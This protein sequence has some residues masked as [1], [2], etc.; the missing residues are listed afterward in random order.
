M[1]ST[2]RV[3]DF[4]NAR[5]TRAM[6]SEVIFKECTFVLQKQF[7]INW[8]YKIFKEELLLYFTSLFSSSV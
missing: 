3:S 8:K 2:V 7:F 4:L 1:V 6:S 5:A